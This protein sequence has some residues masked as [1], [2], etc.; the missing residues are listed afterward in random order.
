MKTNNKLTYS[1]L[2]ELLDYDPSTG[3]FCWIAKSSPS[4]NNLKLGAAITTVGADGYI[5][6]VID[7]E[8]Y[9]AHRLAWMFV[10]GSF[11]SKIIDHINRDKTD[12]RISNLREVSHVGNSLNTNRVVNAKGYYWCNTYKKW[13]SQISLDGK[14]KNLGYFI[15][16]QDAK[17]AYE[18]AL[19][20]KINKEI[21]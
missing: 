19:S 7:G 4:H 5:K 3:F 11:P 14:R 21:V 10:H 13:R 18:N 1:R 15:N 2:I 6:I 8:S 9:K 16:E 20:K 12:N 17:R